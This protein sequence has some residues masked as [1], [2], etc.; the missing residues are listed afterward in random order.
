MGRGH[1]EW[2]GGV[3]VA[4]GNARE[5]GA[6]HDDWVSRKLHKKCYK[7]KKREGDVAE[8]AAAYERLQ[9]KAAFSSGICL[10]DLSQ[11]T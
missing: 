4:V 11:L 10:I 8:V 3:L 5:N 6:D 7:E 2:C 9:R 1:C